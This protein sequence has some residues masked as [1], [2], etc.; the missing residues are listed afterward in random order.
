MI[1]HESLVVDGRTTLVF[2]VLVL[3]LMLSRRAANERHKVSL[4]HSL[5]Q[6]HVDDGHNRY[7]RNEHDE[8][9]ERHTVTVVVD[10]VVDDDQ[11]AES[12]HDE[13]EHV[14]HEVD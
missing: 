1:D 6:D 10:A 14:A 2:D 5:E 11:R 8:I 13:R 7:E 4:G 3:F 9:G 12:K